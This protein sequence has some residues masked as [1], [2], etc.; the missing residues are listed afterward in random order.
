MKEMW[1]LSNGEI[2]MRGK[3]KV[4][5]ENSVPV[6]LSPPWISHGLAWALTVTSR[7]ETADMARPDRPSYPHLNCLHQVIVPLRYKPTELS[8]LSYI[9]NCSRCPLFRTAVEWTNQF[10]I[11][12]SLEEVFGTLTHVTVA[13]GTFE[14][15]GFHIAPRRFPSPAKLDVFRQSH[16][17]LPSNSLWTVICVY[18]MSFV[19]M[20]WASFWICIV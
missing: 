18:W 9:F 20:Q 3:I 2:T 12:E 19:F 8:V 5:G 16:A 13:G 10:F 15:W 1:I 4:L 14:K 6:P 17:H 11:T 7:W